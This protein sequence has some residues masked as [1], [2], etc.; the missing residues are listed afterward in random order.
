MA[1]AVVTIICIAI[2]VMGG[3]ILTQG[4]LNSADATA[5]SVE[6]ITVREGELTRTSLEAVGAAE[7]SWP[8]LLRVTVRNEGQT[9][10]AGFNRWDVI[11]DYAGAG[12]ARYSRRLS[13]TE[14]DL[15]ANRWRKARIGLDGPVDFFEPGI[16]NPGEELVILARLDPPPGAPS[17][18]EVTIA[19][20]NGA[21][22]SAPFSD[23]GYTLLV[24]LAENTTL[25]ASRYYQ[26]E[27]D[28]PAEA[29]GTVMYAEFSEN[30]TGRKILNNEAQPAREARHV[31][32]LV[33]VD[34]IP[35]AA[36]TVYYHCTTDGD[37]FP[38][39]D[40]QVSF[41]IDILIR[42]ADGAV[43]QT[44]ATDVATAYFPA[45]SAG[46]WTTVSGNYTFPGYEVV[47]E[48]DYLEVVYNGHVQ[49]QEPGAGTGYM[50]L[51]VDDGALPPDEQT[52]IES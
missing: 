4:A 52:R 33:G 32:P 41:D 14:G 48:N 38:S 10:L 42:Q 5:L 34:Q 28:A 2:I 39:E 36:W 31:F 26:L 47:D 7:L 37:D 20:D 3:L 29:A 27:E 18:G 23:P 50:R 45:A 15:A 6:D 9:K 44:I 8:D 24:P 51:D 25:A 12:G 22:C 16:L 49:R 21:G 40:G 35:A 43:R 30:E 13:Y 19:A 11:V 46:S 17:S 1:T